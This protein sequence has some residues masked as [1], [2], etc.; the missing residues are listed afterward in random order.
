MAFPPPACYTS[1]MGDTL[2]TRGE[3]LERA[4]RLFLSRGYNGFS[5][6]DIA[7]PIGI[8][9]A[10]VHYHFPT[11]ED[12]GVALVDGYRDVLRDSTADFMQRGG[13]PINQLEG[14]MQLVA[15]SFR[16]Q[17]SICPMGILAVDFFTLPERIRRHAQFLVEEILDWM[18]RVLE[19]G[20]NEGTYDFS[21]PPRAKAVSIKATLQGAAQLAR[22]AGPELLQLAVD[23]IRRDLRGI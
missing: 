12:L 13:N 16:D 11:K 19:T 14:Y 9:N 10:A 3:I 1:G 20:R 22:I 15:D 6:R 23:Q 18:T 4:G 17:Q 7:K 2:D 21:G 8:R 5:Y